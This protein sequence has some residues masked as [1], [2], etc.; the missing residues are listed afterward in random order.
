[1]KRFFSL[2]TVTMVM[3]CGLPSCVSNQTRQEQRSVL[4]MNA[5]YKNPTIQYTQKDAVLDISVK[6]QLVPEVQIGEC[7][8][9]G[10]DTD[11]ACGDCRLVFYCSDECIKADLQRHSGKCALLRQAYFGDL[12]CMKQACFA[13][14]RQFMRKPKDQFYLKRGMSWAQRCVI[15][16]L[17]DVACSKDPSTIAALEQF[18]MELGNYLELLIKNNACSRE[19]FDKER[20]EVMP[21]AIEWVTRIT[22]S[23]DLVPPFAIRNYGLTV[24]SNPV[25]DPAKEFI[26]ESEWYKKRM[27]VLQQCKQK[28]DALSN[29]S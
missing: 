16:I 10:C 11:N 3:L 21:E 26:P 8:Y 6:P 23:K 18:Y 20:I 25:L 19:K 13:F 24:F 9:C 17:Q 5:T 14:L 2:F 12:E 27:N 1:M 15:R 29:K 4:G 7:A 22:Q 28:Y